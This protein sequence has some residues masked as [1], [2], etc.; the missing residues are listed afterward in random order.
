MEPTPANTHAH[1]LDLSLSTTTTVFHSSGTSHCISSASIPR[2]RSFHTICHS[3]IQVLHSRYLVRFGRPRCIHII[4][5]FN[6]PCIIP[7]CQR[8]PSTRC[9]IILFS[10]PPHLTF[11]SIHLWSATSTHS[12]H[13]P[14]LPLLSIATLLLPFTAKPAVDAVGH[15][16]LSLLAYLIEP[17]KVGYTQNIY[18]TDR[19]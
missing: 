12:I 9:T 17:V 8:V 19:N 6:I 2:T 18:R 5:I 14:F 10:A 15:W 11:H 13:Y 7:A 16:T 1:S 3:F 4:H